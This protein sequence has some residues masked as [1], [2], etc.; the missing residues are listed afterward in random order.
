MK[1]HI[2][3]FYSGLKLTVLNS[4]R[5][6]QRI[7]RASDFSLAEIKPTVTNL[8]AVDHRKT[9]LMGNSD[10]VGRPFSFTPFGHIFANCSTNIGFTGERLDLA[11]GC[12]PLGAGRRSYSP[13]LMRFLSGDSQSPFF[14]GGTN[15]YA[16]CLND[17]INY[18]DPS[19]CTGE[20]MN[21]IR[22]KVLRRRHHRT[23]ATPPPY[24]PT[25]PGVPAQPLGAAN[26]EQA[27]PSYFG[28]GEAPPL[29]DQN[30]PPI[31]SNNR[32][33]PYSSTPQP[34]ESV[35]ELREGKLIM[36]NSL[37]EITQAKSLAND[38]ALSATIRLNASNTL[39]RMSLNNLPTQTD[40]GI[41]SAIRTAHQLYDIRGAGTMDAP[42]PT[43]AFALP[44]ERTRRP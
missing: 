34:R 1:N 5:E 21:R 43:Q 16:Y 6:T 32:S 11:S 41:L 37:A 26:S 25:P 38:P 33:R 30:A 35:L 44:V 31:N 42:E 2:L 23:P 24:S 40:S 28:W 12:Y 8:Q 39:I 27:P 36:V 14:K 9:P 10:G 13:V 15:A 18:T 7:F 3:F 29:Y 17:P 22:S 4:S 20:F 19:G